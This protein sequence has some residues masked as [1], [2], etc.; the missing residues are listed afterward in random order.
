MIIHGRNINVK[1]NGVII[2]KA[3][4]SQ[5]NVQCDVTEISSATSGTWKQFLAGRKEWSVEVTKYVEVV[6]TGFDLV[7]QEVTLEFGQVSASNRGQL[8]ADKVSGSAIVT[9]YAMSGEV[10]GL[11]QA[12]MQFQG[13]G[14]L[15]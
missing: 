11:A 7:G 13:S 6:K 15:G 3:R 5:M 10:G 2:A 4:S 12:Q 8:S 1:V 14:P 9:M